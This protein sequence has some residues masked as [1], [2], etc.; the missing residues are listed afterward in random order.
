M[1]VTTTVWCCCRKRTVLSEHTC[2]G[3]DVCVATRALSCLTAL[4][5]ITLCKRA[6]G[7]SAKNA[8]RSASCLWCR[9]GEG[10]RE[11]S[12][13]DRRVM[14]FSLGLRRRGLED[15]AEVSRAKQ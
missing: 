1:P 12:V 11:P 4:D 3:G 7:G 9:L 13:G 10:K 14:L 15:A 6:A 5:L 8:W 2:V